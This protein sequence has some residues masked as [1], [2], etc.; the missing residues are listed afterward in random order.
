M[1]KFM[2][3]AYFSFS[4]LTISSIAAIFYFDILCPLPFFRTTGLLYSLS[5][6][7]V[8]LRAED[9]LATVASLRWCLC[10]SFSLLISYWR[11]FLHFWLL[12]STESLTM[13]GK[14]SSISSVSNS[15][16]GLIAFWSKKPLS[17][18]MLEVVYRGLSL[19]LTSYI[20]LNL[21]W[22]R[23]FLTVLP[24]SRMY[25]IFL[26]YMESRCLPDFF[27]AFL[28]SSYSSSSN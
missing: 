2:W 27:S 5:S 11:F 19:L 4:I 18:N 14:S 12:S 28:I 7:V 17:S 20:L 23:L 21:F 22:W 9:R 15:E 1:V 24:L 26:N 13:V 16:K 25:F 8:F 3:Q 6:S 10:F